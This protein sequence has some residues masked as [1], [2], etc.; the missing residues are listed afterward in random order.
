[1]VKNL[2]A[3]LETQVKSLGWE[4]P[5][6]KE[7][8]THSSILFFFFP[9]YLCTYFGWAGSLLHRFSLL[10]QSG[11]SYSRVVVWELLTVVASLCCRAQALG[12]SSIRN[13]GERA[14]EHLGFSRC[15]AP[16][17]LLLSTWILPDQELNPCPPALAGRF[18]TT[19]PPGKSHW[20]ILAWRIPWTEGP[21]GPQSMGS[22]RVGH[23]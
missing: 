18:S 7:M 13:Y 4:D 15:G 23:D 20:S 2:P 5:L 14:L 21:R 11:V 3:M 1:M 12:L 10:R 17:Q 16:A 22:Q 6:E 9:H 8:A 19:E